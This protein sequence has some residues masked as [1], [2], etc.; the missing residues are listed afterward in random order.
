MRTMC[1]GMYPRLVEDSERRR[2]HEK[3]DGETYTVKSTFMRRSQLQPA[4]Y[5]A[6]AGGKMIATYE[7][8]YQRGSALLRLSSRRS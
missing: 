7:K 4:M 8:R 2:L 6:A 1:P 3:D 5:N